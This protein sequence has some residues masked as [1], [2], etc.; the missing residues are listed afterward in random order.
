MGEGDTWQ[1][2]Q[3]THGGSFTVVGSLRLCLLHSSALHPVGNTDF[4]LRA[5]LLLSSTPLVL[6]R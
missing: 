4:P 2:Q 6:S 5:T 3:S 1:N